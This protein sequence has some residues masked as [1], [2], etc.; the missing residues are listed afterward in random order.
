MLLTIKDK[1]YG[2][3]FGQGAFEPLEDMYNLNCW[4][5]LDKIFIEFA[6]NRDKTFRRLIY[7]AIK[8][9][10]RKTNTDCRINYDEFVEFLDHPDFE[11]YVEPCK[12]AF[13][14]SY[15]QRKSI[16]EWIDEAQN[17]LAQSMKEDDKTIKKK[18]SKTTAR[19]SSKGATAGG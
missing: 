17:K 11:P 19:K 6:S 14:S 15:L 13:L 7:E 18:T 3:T 5:V 16:Q 2:L 4:E 12:D 9:W 1:E 8:C 10:C